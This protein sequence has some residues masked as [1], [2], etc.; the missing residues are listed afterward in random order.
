VADVVV[1]GG[2]P[3]VR[4]GQALPLLRRS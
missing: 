2:A 4:H 1:R 3:H